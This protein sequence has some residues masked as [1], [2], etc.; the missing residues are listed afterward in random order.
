PQSAPPP[1]SLFPDLSRSK[2]RG[3]HSRD[4]SR[5][6]RSLD[7]EA[8]EPL[9]V[10]GADRLRSRPSITSVIVSEIGIPLSRSSQKNSPAGVTSRNT[11]FPW[12]VTSTSIAP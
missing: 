6:S 11:S 5:E 7:L 1:V 3:R 9:I 4:L 2:R 8:A 10:N 12:G